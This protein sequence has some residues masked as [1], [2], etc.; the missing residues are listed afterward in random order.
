[1]QKLTDETGVKLTG[2]FIPHN[3]NLTFTSQF[4]TSKTQNERSSY[5]TSIGYTEV[6]K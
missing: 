5:V 4:D 2:I 1:M 6:T 3:A